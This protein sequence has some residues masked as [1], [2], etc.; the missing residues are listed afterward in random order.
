[1]TKILFVIMFLFIICLTGCCAAKVEV[2]NYNYEAIPD[3]NP[4]SWI[5]EI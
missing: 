1:M 3:M 4:K 2:P 5:R